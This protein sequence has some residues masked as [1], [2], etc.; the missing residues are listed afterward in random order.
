MRRER[1]CYAVAGL[2]L[3]PESRSRSG[4]TP[5]GGPRLSARAKGRGEKGRTG[6]LT[7]PGERRRKQL[8]GWAARG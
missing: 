6:G 4:T 5:T 2:E 3:E 1:P 7:G 8:P